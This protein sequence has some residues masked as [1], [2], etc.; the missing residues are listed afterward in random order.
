MGENPY[1]QY[2]CGYDYLEHE[3][4]IHP[5]SLIKWRHRLGESGLTKILGG[6]IA[7]AVS[8]GAIKKKASKKSLLIQQ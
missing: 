5:T 4:P 8:S 1:W 6:T 2:F 3:I 7:A